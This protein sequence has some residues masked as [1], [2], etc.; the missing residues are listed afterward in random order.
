MG[1]SCKGTVGG[2]KGGLGKPRE[3]M[4]S[5]T[6]CMIASEAADRLRST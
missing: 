4:I 3:D 5:R 1:R 2:V 6:K